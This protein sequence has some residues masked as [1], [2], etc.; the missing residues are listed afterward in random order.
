[1]K[2]TI[3]F[4]S[5]AA[6]ITLMA[7]SYSISA[8]LLLSPPPPND[9]PAPFLGNVSPSAGGGAIMAQASTN[10]S[11]YTGAASVGIPLH[12]LEGDNLSHSVGLS[13]HSNGIRVSEMASRVGLGWNLSAGGAITRMVRGGYADDFYDPF[14]E[15]IELF[16]WEK[17]HCGFLNGGGDIK[18][19]YGEG[20]EP[21]D[22]QPD[23]FYFS[24]D[25]YAGK[26]VF[27]DNQNIV[28]LPHSNL[29]I[30]ETLDDET[31]QIIKFTVTTDKGKKYTFDQYEISNQIR[32]DGV[33]KDIDDVEMADANIKREYISTWYLSTIE[34]LNTGSVTSG[35]AI[36][37]EYENIDELKAIVG[38]SETKLQDI[39]DCSCTENGLDEGST[40][41]QFTKNAK[42]L[43]SITSKYSKV[44]LNHTYRDDWENDFAIKGMQIYSFKDANQ[45]N[46][47]VEDCISD[48]T[49][50]T[51][52]IE[53]CMTDT[54]FDGPIG[55]PNNNALGVNY[56]Y[57]E[58][59]CLPSCAEDYFL[60]SYKFEH[61]YFNSASN[62]N[63][64]EF[65]HLEYRLK[66]NKIITQNK[67]R[68]TANDDDNKVLPYVFSYGHNG[69]DLPR[70]PSRISKEQDIW[71]FYNNNGEGEGGTLLPKLW[72]YPNQNNATSFMPLQKPNTTAYE[73]STEGAN[74]ESNATAIK[75]GLL[76]LVKYPTGNT[77]KFDYQIHDFH[78]DGEI[79]NGGGVRVHR[80]ENKIGVHIES[81][82]EYEYT[83]PLGE[84]SGQLAGMPQFAYAC[85][86]LTYPIIPNPQNQWLKVDD[87]LAVFS[88]SQS[89][90]GATKGSHVGYARV[91]EKTAD[92]VN[93][94]SNGYSIYT[95]THP[96]SPSSTCT[97]P[98]DLDE[99]PTQPDIQG[100]ISYEISGNNSCNEDF[101]ELTGQWDHFPFAPDSD[102][103]HRRGL[104]LKKEDF[105]NGGNSVQTMVN[106]YK[107]HPVTEFTFELKQQFKEGEFNNIFFRTGESTVQSEFVYLEKQTHT[108]DE[109]TT[110]TSYNYDLVNHFVPTG[111]TTTGGSQTITSTIEYP[112]DG[113][114]GSAVSQMLQLNWIGVPTSTTKTLD[115][116][117]IEGSLTNFKVENGI[118][119]PQHYYEI[120]NGEF[121][122]VWTAKKWDASGRV[123]EVHQLGKDETPFPIAHEFTWDAGQLT[124]KK[125]K[126]F[127]T[128]Y[129]YYENRLLESQTDEEGITTRYYYDDLFPTIL[130]TTELIAE[131]HTYVSTNYIHEYLP[132]KVTT[133]VD[134]TDPTD[135]VPE[136]HQALQQ[137]SYKLFDLF[138]RHFSTTRVRKVAVLDQ[139]G[140][141]TGE[142]TE[143]DKVIH[144]IEYDG[145]GRATSEYKMGTGNT[146]KSYEY[147]PL[148]RIE[149]VIDA[150]GN[151]TTYNYLGAS[152]LI[153]ETDANAFNSTEIID[154]SGASTIQ[155]VD[156]LGRTTGVQNA[157]GEQTLYTYHPQGYLHTVQP[158]TGTPYIYTYYESDGQ[159]HTKQV[160]GMDGVITYTYDNKY[161]LETIKD[162]KGQ[163]L[164]T[165][166]DEYDRPLKIFLKNEADELK[167]SETK[168]ASASNRVEWTKAHKVLPSGDIDT[169]YFQTTFGYDVLGRKTN[170]SKQYMNDI[171]ATS[172]A[173]YNAAGIAYAESHSSGGAN[174]EIGYE[175]EHFSDDILRLEKTYMT[176][177]E[178][179]FLLNK[180]GYDG[181]DRV[182]TKYLHAQNSAENSF[183]Q[184]IN[185]GYDAIGRLTSINGVDSNNDGIFDGIEGSSVCR[186]LDKCGP[187]QCT[188]AF[189]IAV[190]LDHPDESIDI[191]RIEAIPEEDR[192]DVNAIPY[193]IPLPNY[194][195]ELSLQYSGVNDRTGL[196]EG[197]PTLDDDGL[198]ADLENWLTAEGHYFD[199]VSVELKE[200]DIPAHIEIGIKS[201]NVAFDNINE[202]EYAPTLEDCC[203]GSWMLEDGQEIADGEEA[204]IPDN[205]SSPDLFAM[206]L[207]YQDPNKDNNKLDIH[208]FH[209]QVAC[210]D[211]QRYKMDYDALH[212]LTTANHTTFLANETPIEGRYNVSVSG[213]DGIGN[214]DRIIRSGVA[215][216]N[217]QSGEPIY[218][219]IDD[220]KYDYDGT[221]NRLLSVEDKI[222]GAGQ[223]KGFAPDISTY[224]Y[225]TNGNLTADVGKKLGIFYNH[226]DLPRIIVKQ[227]ETDGTG[228]GNIAMTYSAAGDLLERT[229]TTDDG[230][231][232]HTY[233]GIAE[234]RSG[235]LYAATFSEGRITL[236]TNEETGVTEPQLEYVYSDHLG[237]NRVL[238][239]D[240]N[241]DGRVDGSEILQ[242]NHYY[243][244]GMNM[245]GPWCIDA[246]NTTKNH[247]QFN[248]IERFD[249][250]DLNIDFAF[251][252]SY[253]PTIGRWWQV[254]PEAESFYGMSVYTGM[255][256]NPLMLNDPNGDA[257]PFMVYAGAALIGGGLN[258]HANWN[259]TSGFWDGLSYF[260]NGAAGGA[261]AV[262]NPKLGM[263][264]T[265]LG[266]IATDWGN[267]TLSQL[268]GQADWLGHIGSTI[269]EATGAAGA[270]SLSRGVFSYL[271]Q[272]GWINFNRVVPLTAE[273]MALAPGITHTVETVAVKTT[274]STIAQNAISHNIA[275]NVGN[276]SKLK[277][278]G[279][280]TKG[281]LISTSTHKIAIEEI[282]PTDL[283][284][285]SQ[286]IYAS[287]SK[288]IDI[289]NSEY[290]MCYF[291]NP[292]Q[293]VSEWKYNPIPIEDYSDKEV[294]IQKRINSYEYEI[295]T[296]APVNRDKDYIDIDY[297]EI[298]PYT[299]KWLQLEIKKSDDTYSK[300]SLRRPNW[301]ILQNN[302]DKV[303]SSV[304][305]SLPEMGVEGQAVVTA[306]TPNQLDTRFW[307]EKRQG[308]Y[309]ARPIT[310]IFEHIRTDV[311]NYYFE[312]LAKPIGA[313][314]VHP[315][316]SIDKMDWVA[317]GELEIGERV[318]TIE[319]VSKLLSKEKLEGQHKVFN[320][321]I[322]QEH[323]F[324]VSKSGVLVHNNSAQEFFPTFA[325]SSSKI[326]PSRT[327]TI[328]D[329]SG[330]L[331]KFGVTDAN[332]VRYNQSL[333]LAGPGA[334]GKYSSIIPKHEAHALEKYLRSL[335]YNS[336]G[337]YTLPGMKV[338]YPRSFDTGLP[339]KP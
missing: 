101:I 283:F 274:T 187:V 302:A 289:E 185:Y 297:E 235:K 51:P 282:K 181:E 148:S 53:T 315:F 113:I 284:L 254:D 286:E 39:T 240:L 157:K 88:D 305:L 317:V 10:V 292:L 227:P 219:L 124:K 63:N 156:L 42:V 29:K 96:G 335:Q 171:V 244:F 58:E 308:D 97:S 319:G 205:Y 267:G 273:E 52:C 277:L 331:F 298:T 239:A 85:K 259:N 69:F 80:K 338:P 310:G 337:Q 89:Q 295:I 223:P 162:P 208:Q 66:L 202:G 213:Y 238:Y 104:L 318:K 121:K 23:L 189:D 111:S 245:E 106:E 173:Q 84:T 303:G 339:I 193:T 127:V 324:L 180:L 61:T 279:C 24:F 7:V 36:S 255:G 242:E 86:E 225:D 234:F 129:T 312:G 48:N 206:I 217:A 32:L 55:S 251:Y 191:G 133:T 50:S 136:E 253:D 321:E 98:T 145:L 164:R 87:D 41:V 177:G 336:T 128:E 54:D 160:P 270:A 325:S 94:E 116:V 34:N 132:R 108:V 81:F 118:V 11:T 105:D 139:N 95:F 77:V 75:A 248:G 115:G 231:Y 291:E 322:Y 237:N 167:L 307:N 72:F 304:Y 178:E 107:A 216:V 258:L 68:G 21:R 214:I 275:R 131:D 119:V 333:K 40:I 210:G 203:G 114:G 316:W 26:F 221:D 76:T 264:I 159:M 276:A 199:K 186:S 47:D 79:Y 192:G 30:E 265:G 243:P 215:G 201:T 228:G 262:V 233:A 44:V 73:L 197:T 18:C 71:G 43:K 306:I 309:V 260:V 60:K 151:K 16:V 4:I 135:A 163:K 6:L 109:V 179:T 229:V 175:Y 195:Y 200:T 287:N 268:D 220:L 13:Y 152:V 19:F 313:T 123:E 62:P 9:P 134:F 99:C 176:L 256:N 138:G 142:S 56:N 190:D 78:Y 300:I 194:P 82:I 209:W 184:E 168:F 1:M 204:P 226:M 161:R 249:D 25:G 314:S 311:S 174:G 154:A 146:S 38:T 188:Y 320:L 33:Q 64:V 3:L 257:I 27:D 35:E 288:N 290:L 147:S 126:D 70:L 92:E 166:Y 241:K 20:T 153:G 196:P 247:Y 299:W 332:L 91:I 59:Q 15:Q 278:P 198:Q 222:G 22:R 218:G 67:E 182:I 57:C 158:P 323:N 140:D 110:E 117:T 334:T 102:M 149:E 49:F 271:Q 65:P 272:K 172:T 137:K 183:L 232:T 296:Y 212:R 169:E 100:S 17:A 266:N 12:T 250:L 130:K 246:V 8:N 144:R 45:F 261:T 170:L 150:E 281:T 155:S 293:L 326:N 230:S 280:F 112:Q 294:E 125:Y 263:A 236:Q 301:W 31:K 90:I 93:N 120:Q 74:R 46:I 211:R 224:S 83:N 330:N 141:P 165:E 14:T 2:H 103:D 28:L 269:L 285:Y 122:K 328:F 143:E 327:Y 329:G 5:V 207:D 37:F 252:R